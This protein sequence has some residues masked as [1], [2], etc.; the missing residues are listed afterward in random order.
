MRTLFAGAWPAI[1]AGEIGCAAV[2]GG[3]EIASGDATEIAEVVKTQPVTMS[4]KAMTK[5]LQ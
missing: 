1:E 3:V 2:S 5:L 4:F